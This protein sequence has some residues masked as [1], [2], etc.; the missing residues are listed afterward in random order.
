[1]AVSPPPKLRLG[2][3]A[4]RRGI[5]EAALPLFARKGFD[6]TTTKEIA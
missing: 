5:V 3:E 1:M 4:R 2:S 6:G